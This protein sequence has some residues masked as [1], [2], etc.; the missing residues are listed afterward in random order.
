MVSKMKSKLDS[1][2]VL[3]GNIIDLSGE[4]ET[5]TKNTSQQKTSYVVHIFQKS[6]IDDLY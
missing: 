1:I 4:R 6:F 2:S 5:V 3:R